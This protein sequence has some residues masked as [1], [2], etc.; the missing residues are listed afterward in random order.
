MSGERCLGRPGRIGGAL[1]A[2]AFR[3]VDPDKYAAGSICG[4]DPVYQYLIRAG[5]TGSFW[6][7]AGPWI[8]PF[9]R[10][11]IGRSI[12]ETDSFVVT[13]S[14]QSRAEACTGMLRLP[15]ASWTSTEPVLNLHRTII[16]F[17]HRDGRGCAPWMRTLHLHLAPT[18]RLPCCLFISG[19]P[20][21]IA[22]HTWFEIPA[23]LAMNA[24]RLSPGWRHAVRPKSVFP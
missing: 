17:R 9:Q 6:D 15:E 13:T 10:C 8:W 20:S 4:R 3:M 11:V 19:T 2:V 24:M 21:S 12:N 22:W 18:S 14:R 16:G 23:M 1:V 7:L 5:P